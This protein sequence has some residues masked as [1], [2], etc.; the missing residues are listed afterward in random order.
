MFVI[1]QVEKQ[2]ARQ[3]TLY[4]GFFFRVQLYKYVH[5]FKK[6]MNKECKLKGYQ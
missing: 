2:I 6:N 3:H 1:Y 4:S 5:S